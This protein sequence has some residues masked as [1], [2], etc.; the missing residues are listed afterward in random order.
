MATPRLSLAT[1]PVR[2]ELYAHDVEQNMM[3]AAIAAV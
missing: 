2:V 3:A 1:A